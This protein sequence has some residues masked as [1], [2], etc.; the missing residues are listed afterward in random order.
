MFITSHDLRTVCTY[1]RNTVLVLS[2]V[3]ATENCIFM[4]DFRV[5]PRCRWSL[6]STPSCYAVLLGG[7]LQTFRDDHFF[8]FHASSSPNLFEPWKSERQTFPKSQEI[9][10]DIRCITTQKSGLCFI[11][12]ESKTKNFF[13]FFCLVPLPTNSQLFH[14]LSHS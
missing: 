5:P 13:F 2:N 7:S 3:A 1:V 9:T 11:S 8:H 10:T 12:S 14:K 4:R 6:P